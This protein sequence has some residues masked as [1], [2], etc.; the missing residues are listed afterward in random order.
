MLGNSQI[1]SNR[2]KEKLK[3]D[4]Y[5]DNYTNKNNYSSFN[6]GFDDK[7]MYIKTDNTNSYEIQSNKI[8]NTL[9]SSHTSFQPKRY[10]SGT[11]K[12]TN[13]KIGDSHRDIYNLRLSK[14]KNQANNMGRK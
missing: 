5:N 4:F 2:I 7:Q 9:K 11:Q 6:S 3:I 8:G 14:L 12:G 13:S 1:T 10:M